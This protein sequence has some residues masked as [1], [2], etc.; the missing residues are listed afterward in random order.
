[1]RRPG[2]EPGSLA[3]EASILPLNH[4]RRDMVASV[5][6]L[7]VDNYP[8]MRFFLP[9]YYRYYKNGFALQRFFLD[10]IDVHEYNLSSDDE[11]STDFIDAYI[12]EMRR[13]IAYGY[14][15]YPDRRNPPH[16]LSFEPKISLALNA[17]DLWTGGM[18]TTVTTL[19]WAIIYL[20]HH[21]EVQ[22]QLFKEID[23]VLVTSYDRGPFEIKY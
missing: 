16:Y 2:I 22:D 21:P 5:Q 18:E 6:M 8:W 19:R 9:T 3:W 15:K 23:T 14:Y 7:M 13:R 20:L 10:H 17:G 12:K 11:E 1:M 4:R